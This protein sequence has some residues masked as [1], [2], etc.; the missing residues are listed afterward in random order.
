VQTSPAEAVDALTDL[1][2]NT[3]AEE[4]TPR[5]DARLYGAWLIVARIVWAVEEPEIL[6][7]NY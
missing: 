4:A 6:L 3:W 1:R 2:H 7:L 5:P